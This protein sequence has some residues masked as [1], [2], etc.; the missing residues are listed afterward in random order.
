MDINE[1]RTIATVGS[2]ILF[3]TILIWTWAKRNSRDFKEAAI[4]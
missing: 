3:V 2:F 1:L 4:C